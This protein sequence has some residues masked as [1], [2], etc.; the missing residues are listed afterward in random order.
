MRQENE[1][2]SQIPRDDLLG[3]LD[4][5]QPGTAQRITAE[6]PI[7][8]EVVVRF[9][10]PTAP[11]LDVTAVIAPERPRLPSW[12]IVAISCALTVLLATL[13]WGVAH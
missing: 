7:P 2:T 3:L 1:T 13:V 8:S 11:R 6:F 10:R 4:T 9:T 12:A 5:M